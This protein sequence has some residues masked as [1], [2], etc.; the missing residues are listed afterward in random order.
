MGCFC[1]VVDRDSF[2]LAVYSVCDM[3]AAVFFVVFYLVDSA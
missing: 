3:V 1:G 2:N